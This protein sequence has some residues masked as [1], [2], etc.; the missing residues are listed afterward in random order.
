[1][2][3]LGTVRLGPFELSLYHAD[4]IVCRNLYQ[5]SGYPRVIVAVGF[6]TGL[7]GLFGVFCRLTAIRHLILCNDAVGRAMR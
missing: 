7:V 6:I 3:Y 5:F 4:V 2:L 1:M